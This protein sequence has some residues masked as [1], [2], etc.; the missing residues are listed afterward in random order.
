MV[1][2]R[3]WDQEFDVVI[4]G[5]GGAGLT[6]AILAHDHGARVAVL[7]RSDKVGGTTAVSGGVVWVPLNHHMQEVGAEDTREEALAYCKRLAAGSVPDE[8]VETYVD[9][10]HQMVRYL[11]EHTPLRF[12]VWTAPDYY[13]DGVG[14]K[15]CG[16]AL[17]PVLFCKRQLGAWEDKLRPAPIFMLPLTLEEMLTKFRLIT[18]VSSLPMDMLV[19]RMGEGLVGCGN[20]LAGALLKGCLDRGVTIMLETRA[21]QLVREGRRVTG[22]RAEQE[23]RDVWLRA[24]GGVI[25]ASGGFEWNADL[26]RK[27]LPGPL[28]HPNSPPFNEGDALIMAM[29]V[30]ADLANMTCA[31]WQPSGA[32]PGEEYEGRPLGR[33]LSSER[34]APHTIMV[35]R[36]GRRFVNEGAPYNDIGRVF[37]HFDPSQ[38]GFRNLPCWAIFDSQYRGKYPVLTVLPGDPDPEWLPKDETIEGLA[39]KVGIDPGGLAETVAR[40]NRMVGEG[41][42]A[43]FRRGETSFERHSGDPR[44]PNPNLGTVEKPPFYALPVYP[45]AL[46]TSG[47]PRINTKGEV[48]DVRGQV[49]PGLYAAGNAAGSPTGVAYYSGG[50]TIGPAMTWGY[51]CGINAALAS[52]DGAP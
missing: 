10:A 26:V 47:G 35:N 4:A 24:R 32:I 43:E 11:E 5:S 7:E 21:V 42:D 51:L 36:Q 38:Y 31:W 49:I 19:Q 28:T 30:G 37:H 14:G 48:L 18:D 15:Q 50:G 17:E 2:D 39:R 12:S 16:R 13:A 8:M 23:G 9:T 25:L 29:E 34:I 45:G 3:R 1:V 44:L 40:W 6:A 27:F 20:A 52:K 33:F 22:L 46:G 41:R